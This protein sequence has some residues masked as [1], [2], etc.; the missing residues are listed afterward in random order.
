MIR[1]RVVV[2]GMGI[3]SPVGST[4]ESAWSNILAGKSSIRP[5]TRYH[6]CAHSTR[7]AGPMAGD[8]VA[9]DYMGFEDLRKID[10]FIRYGVAAAKQALRDAGLEASPAQ[11]ELTHPC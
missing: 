4:L 6:I 10:P 2:T 3:V 8:F 7:F 5:V 11:S 1:R 9:Q